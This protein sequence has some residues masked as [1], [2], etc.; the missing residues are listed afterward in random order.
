MEFNLDELKKD[1]Q[2]NYLAGALE[3]LLRE[4]AEVQEMLDSDDTLHEMAAKELKYIQEKKD[5]IEKQ[6]EDILEKNIK[7]RFII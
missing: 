5:V 1:H 6:L 2:T 4:E 7:Y 3:K